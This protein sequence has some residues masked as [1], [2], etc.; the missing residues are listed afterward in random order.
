MPVFDD[1]QEIPSLSD[2]HRGEPEIV[3][4]EDFGLEQFFHDIRIR[5]IGP[6]D[7]HFLKEAG[8]A[9]IESW[10]AHPACSVC[11]G[12]RQVGFAH[13]GRAGDDNVLCVADPVAI[14]QGKDDGLDQAPG[15]FVVD[16]LNAAIDFEVCILKEPFHLSILLEGPLLVYKEREAV[17]ELQV[18]GSGLPEL[19]FESLGHAIEFHGIEFFDGL[20][21]K[22]CDPP[23]SGNIFC[24]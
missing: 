2:G 20:F 8:Q 19:I 24:P 23:F 18:V 11:K 7:G 17:L 21:G 5:S 16:V 1:L 14:G 22:H 15:G 13:T 9:D 6:G 12:A 3:D 4:D 10:E